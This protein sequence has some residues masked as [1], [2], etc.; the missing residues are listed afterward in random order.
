LN[1]TS[2]RNR[3]TAAP[4]A[5]LVKNRVG[6]MLSFLV[7]AL[8]FACATVQLEHFPVESK[9]PLSLS[10]E[11]MTGT[12]VDSVFL[13]AM[14]NEL[15]GDYVHSVRE[16]QRGGPW[17]LY[18]ARNPFIYDSGGGEKTTGASEAPGGH[19][20]QLAGVSEAPG[21]PGAI[22]VYGV[23][24][25]TFYAPFE[26]VQLALDDYAVSGIAGGA[27][28]E[29]R[30]DY[31]VALEYH[32][33]SDVRPKSPFIIQV[34]QHANAMTTTRREHEILASEKAAQELLVRL[35]EELVRNGSL[36]LE[37]FSRRAE[38]RLEID[39]WLRK[40]TSPPAD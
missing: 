37:I 39:D 40:I 19:G 7:I 4:N 34:A 25:E 26:S 18:V 28:L 22:R 38:S 31:I 8:T 12:G 14:E 10:T 5:T 36:D 6:T 16:I 11:D 29:D 9:V 15:A 21:V 23:L 1:F 3:V 30:N 2:A 33:F 27:I 24:H 35:A 20:D 17:K 32:F 13:L